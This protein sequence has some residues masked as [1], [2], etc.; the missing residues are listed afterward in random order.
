[1]KVGY[2]AKRIRV[3]RLR[4]TQHLA[5]YRSN[6]K[7]QSCLLLFAWLGIHVL[8]AQAPVDLQALK[9][10]HIGPLGNRVSAVV[11]VPGTHTY[12]VGSASGGIFKTTDGGATWAPVFDDQPVLSMGAL[13]IAESDPNLIWAGTGEAHIRSN[14]SVGN[15][16]YLSTDA[17]KN[18]RHM[19]LDRTG[20]TSRIVIHPTN[21]DVVLVAA[22]GHCY[23]PQQE[24][25]VYRTED[26][27][28]TWQRVLFV[29]EN[30]GASDLIMDPD[31]PRI[32]FA[33]T[34]QMTIR[35]WGRQS[36]GPGSGIYKS[37]D[38]GRSW[39]RL[40]GNGLPD[41][42][43]GKIALALSRADSERVY[44]LIETNS[45]RDFEPLEEHQG[46]LWASDDSGA[47]WRLVNGDHTLAQRPIYYTR[48]VAAPD[49]ENEL[50]FLSTQASISLDGGVTSRRFPIAG[51]HHD[52]WV[53][54]GHPSRMI[55]GHDQGV[56][57]SLNRGKSWLRPQ[58]PIAQIYHAYT[59]NRI[60]YRV[61]GNRQDGPSM[62]GPSNTLSG[63]VIPIGAW[64]SVGGCESGFAIPDPVDNQRV[65]SGCYEG[66]L[67]LFDHRTGHSRNVSVWPDNPEAWSG[68]TLKYRFQWTFPILISPHDHN[69]VYVGSQYVHLT[70]DGGHSWRVIS[71]D[72]TTNDKTKQQRMGGLTPDDAGPTMGATLFALAES[73][74]QAGLLWAGSNDGLLHV[75]QDG[76]QSWTNLTDR[77]PDLPPWG[78]VSNIEASRHQAGAAYVTFDL[79]QV[80]DT[81]SYVYKTDDF[82]RSWVSLAAD[83]PHDT[84]SYVHCLREDPQRAGLLYL[85]TENAIHVSFDD[86]VDWQSLQTNLPQAPAHWLTVQEHFND[87][88]VA[89]YGRGFWIL[90]DITP[91]Q[92]WTPEVAGQAAYLFR[93][94]PAYRF[95][96]VAA[97]MQQPGD[98]AAGQNPSYG[99]SLNYYLSDPG[100]QEIE[101]TISDA[102]GRQVRRLGAGKL[103][104]AKPDPH[105]LTRRAGLNRVYWDLR[106]QATDRPRLRTKPDEHAHVLLGEDGWRPLVEGRPLALLAPPGEYTIKLKVDNSEQIQQLTVL[107]DPNSAGTLRTIAQQTELLQQLREMINQAVKMINRIERIRAQLYQLQGYLE[108]QEDIEEILTASRELDHKLKE[109]EGNFFD[110]R[111]TNA[112]QD[113]LWWGRRLYSKMTILARQIGQSDFAPTTQQ[114]EVFQLYR[115]Q[116]T[117]YRER[118]DKLLS[119]DVAGFNRQLRRQ[120]IGNIIS[121]E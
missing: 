57:I 12:Y 107:K 18:W 105:R 88:V 103:D 22:L 96:T 63:S 61:Y 13:A 74:L 48:V 99:A 40:T 87:L 1:M 26:G 30:T 11:G 28:Q 36:G 76:G 10:R 6:L 4:M 116:L 62:G 41:P 19:G 24:R 68:E 73:P 29:D 45:N 80:N 31:N 94:R 23:G 84:H 7:L 67:D 54:P 55:V 115:K 78:T 44:A 86:G 42:P 53:D 66:I 75:S 108:D 111:L 15:G 70:E 39:R 91:L 20:R 95:R 43:W 118:L 21:P 90:D 117:N 77:L 50:Y 93:P 16:V 56:S 14:V 33:A 52:L 51:D 79:H 49:D 60:P 110:L 58:L 106:Y 102:Q 104:P 83:L 98:P 114:Q 8:A 5:S 100:Q 120:G 71:P 101:L 35:T 72:L 113:T 82:G 97:N 47:N 65:W 69:R 85:G 2:T 64:Q 121:G 38:G 17:G 89:T 92:Q 112:R 46:V 27:G 59:D 34:W 119:E 81:R 109:L 9:Y 25:G 32:L 37:T 3:G